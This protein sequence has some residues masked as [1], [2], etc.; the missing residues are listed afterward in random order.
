[1]IELFFYFEKEEKNVFEEIVEC[2]LGGKEKLRGCDY[3]FVVVIV[4]Y[5]LRGKSCVYI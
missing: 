2:L 3:R 4:V 5:Y 1:M